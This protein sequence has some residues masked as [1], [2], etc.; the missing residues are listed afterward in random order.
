MSL[1]VAISDAQVTVEDVQRIL[2]LGR[3]LRSVL[4]ED[5]LMELERSINRSTEKYEVPRIDQ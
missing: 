1:D 5:E 3:I 4:T 2:D